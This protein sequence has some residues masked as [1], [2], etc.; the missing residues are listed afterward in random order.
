M[1]DSSNTPNTTEEQDTA[2]DA[3]QG[4]SDDLFSRLSRREAEAGR[5]TPGTHVDTHGD[6]VQDNPNAD[7]I[8][9]KDTESAGGDP[10]LYRKEEDN[11]KSGK[12][13]LNLGGKGKGNLGPSGGV[14][15]GVL[16]GMVAIGG[17]SI[18][19]FGNLLIN[20]KE[21]FHN[22]QANSSRVNHIYS[23][24][25]FA[26]K[27]TK[28][29]CTGKAPILCRFQK[30]G[31]RQ[32]AKLER[33]GF[34]V[35][36]GEK[37]LLGN[38]SE[39]KSIKFPSGQVAETG[40][41]FHQIANSSV[42]NARAVRLATNGK[43]AFYLNSK[44]FD[45]YDRYKINKQKK[46]TEKK[47][48]DLD[49]QLDR[50]TNGTEAEG[51]DETR[52]KAAEDK[53]KEEAKKMTDARYRE[54][55]GE[56]R[57]TA[58]RAGNI[59]IVVAGVCGVYNLSRKAI[60]YS[61]DYHI[62]QLIQYSSLFMT[63]A[64]GTK[65][66]G[67]T[68]PEAATYAGDILTSYETNEK[69]DDGTPNEKY[70]K[71]ATD[72][73]AYETAA[74]GDKSETPDY[75]KKYR[76]GGYSETE[77]KGWLD[78]VSEYID[79]VERGASFLRPENAVHLGTLGALFDV[80]SELLKNPGDPMQAM[81]SYLQGL[82]G[83]ANADDGREA[84]RYYCANAD[85]VAI[86]AF[87]AVCGVAIL[88]LFTVVATAPSAGTLAMCAIGAACMAP[89]PS[90]AA[91][92][93]VMEQILELGKEVSDKTGATDYV[94]SLLQSTAV[95]SFTKGVEAGE[96]WGAG[97]AFF[98]AAVASA[99][100]LKPAKTPQEATKFVSSTQ[101]DMEMEEKLAYVDARSTPFNVS[102]RHSLFGS[103]VWSMQPYYD[104][105]SPIFSGIASLFSAVPNALKSQ[106]PAVSAYYSQPV[107]E[108][109]QRYDCEDPDLIS[110]GI[111]KT[112]RFCST[113]GILPDDELEAGRKQAEEENKLIEDNIAYMTTS[114]TK[115]EGGGGTLDDSFCGIG[116]C[117][118]ENRKNSTQASIDENGKVIA[119]SQ[120]ERYITYCTEQRKAPWGMFMEAIQDASSTR[121]IKW[122]T[123]QQCLE[124]SNMMK[125]FRT[126]YNMCSQS[127]TMDDET[128]CWETAAPAQSGGDWVSPLDVACQDGFGSRGGAHKGVDM[129]A[130]QGTSVKAPT[131]LEITFVG[132]SSDGSTGNQVTAKA[133]DG[134][135]YS[136][137]FMHLQE[138]PPFTAGQKV[139]KG[140]E[141]GK[142][143]STGNSTGP[144]LHMDVFPSGNTGVSYSGQVDPVP[145]FA[146]HGVT[147]TC[148]S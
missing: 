109:I 115:N 8:E 32:I 61:K 91:C 73:I 134:S 92:Q 98:G 1:A 44:M 13:R 104:K 81:K 42:E 99:Y 107:Q 82:G 11:S 118:E 96:A 83:R 116:S 147:I 48:S 65:N 112:D 41:Q 6:T 58:G 135:D 141:V 85:N 119:K 130:P 110:I 46:L 27:M 138:Q 51:D 133:T 93:R 79:K 54:F 111:E 120:Y 97:N 38:R 123:G 14:F 40:K 78:K 62:Q 144:H 49:K 125:Q 20:I 127:A 128:N 143:G 114:Q 67:D 106:D 23:N 136:F 43:A 25:M 105:N 21:I 126:Y 148:Q 94:L 19:L 76:A 101:G 55:T 131:D 74:H 3:G 57:K 15:A 86:A 47:K 129:A 10:S 35:E 18:G 139:R 84:I 137:R 146:D 108:P 71:A 132:T 89:G 4:H 66:L 22:D 26:S 17:G 75:A 33:A 52:K 34:T 5:G 37:N 140:E 45:V 113:V 102:D 68:T 60:A 39:I 59:A 29:K 28:G 88:G 124:E 63:E 2:H 16:F 50:N 56:V 121:D 64:D 30:M 100:G 36:R 103:V 117:S 122:Y 70:N 7:A 80:G 72:S 69:N 87:V 9:V 31:E 142:V 24:A 77:G 95:G 12:G 53:A 90:R 145:V